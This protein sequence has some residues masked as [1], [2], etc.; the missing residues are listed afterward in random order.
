MCVFYPTIRDSCIRFDVSNATTSQ[1]V[2]RFS[3]QLSCFATFLIYI[4]RHLYFSQ[5]FILKTCICAM[6]LSLTQSHSWHPYVQINFNI[7]L[8]S[9]TLFS[10]DTSDFFYKNHSRFLYFEFI[11]FFFF[12]MRVPHVNYLSKW[13]PNYFTSS[14]LG[15]TSS[16]RRIFEF[17]LFIN[18]I[19]ADLSSLIDI[20]HRPNQV[21]KVLTTN[22]RLLLVVSTR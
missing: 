13:I 5:D 18:G 12:S 22:W 10:R 16:L 2:W 15:T 3:F 19:G 11:S 14:L 17:S 9:D 4:T 20:R 21:D 1:F 6:L 8:Y 7:C